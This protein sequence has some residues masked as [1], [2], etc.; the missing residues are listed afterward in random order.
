MSALHWAL[1]ECSSAI[2][3]LLESKAAVNA[4]NSEGMTPLHQAVGLHGPEQVEVVKLLLEADADANLAA[5]VREPQ[6]P[7]E[8]TPSP[9]QLAMK[10]SNLR[11]LQAFCEAGKANKE[12]MQFLIR[13]EG[14]DAVEALQSWKKKARI[15][16]SSRRGTL[17]RK[18]VALGERRA[19]LRE[20][21]RTVLAA[22][23]RKGELDAAQE[24]ATLETQNLYHTPAVQVDLYFLPGLNASDAYER[25]MLKAMTETMNEGIF[26]TEVVEAVVSAAWMQLRASTAW[27]IVSNLLNVA[28][29]CYTSFSF[30]SGQQHSSVSLMLVALLHGKKTL[31]KL[32]QYI[33]LFCMQR[34]HI[35]DFDNLADVAYITIGWCAILRQASA[36]GLEKPFMGLFSA[37]AWLRALYTFRGE[38]WM[39]P[40]LLPILSA[41]KDTKA[42]FV[43]TGTCLLAATHCY[44]NLQMRGEPTPSYAAFLQVIRLGIFGDFDLHEFEGLD[45]TYQMNDENHHW[46]PQDPD[47]GPD[48]VWAHALFYCIGVGIFLLLMNLFV[49]VLSQNFELYEDQSAVLFYRARAKML[50]ELQARPW[51]YLIFSLFSAKIEASDDSEAQGEKSMMRTL[52]QFSWWPLAPFWIAAFGKE[53]DHGGLEREALANHV[54]CLMTQYRCGSVLLLIFLPVS[55][56]L[57]AILAVLFLLGRCVFQCQ[58][59]GLFYTVAVALGFCGPGG[60]ATA[61]QSWIW[62]VLRPE[63]PVED[64]RSVRSEVKNSLLKVQDRFEKK[65]NELSSAQEE[66]KD[67]LHGMEDT[68]LKLQGMQ[69]D[70]QGQ[71]NGMEH[72]LQGVEDTL[73]GMETKLEQLTT[74]VETLVQHPR[75]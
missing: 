61:Q 19:H 43:V 44:Y 64:L 24:Y 20:R 23:S 30:R 11:A 5:K 49:G 33:S 68:L 37:L 51:K 39:G 7:H 16:H 70:R 22:P 12:L 29:L 3:F 57:S 13:A 72:K 8:P 28:L 53:P 26:Q 32:C 60:T 9:L 65:I 50:L 54:V 67:L 1:Q 56:A 59:P 10:E 17:R 31:E 66:H 18:S 62:V 25:E 45:T 36:S 74:L 2:P 38:T 75:D 63:A 46:E 55:F 27:E 4:F 21:L 73:Q 15:Q 6:N 47:P 69:T 40:R 41:I 52:L 14:P 58:L 35:L 71:L 34:I 42:F 48:Y